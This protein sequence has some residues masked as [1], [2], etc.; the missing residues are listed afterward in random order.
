MAKRPQVRTQRIDGNQEQID[1]LEY[2]LEQI[3][4]LLFGAEGEDFRVL[5]G[6]VPRTRNLSALISRGRQA[7]LDV[8]E[9]LRFLHAELG[10]R[11]GPA[12]AGGAPEFRA[13]LA[14]FR[15]HRYQTLLDRPETL[16]DRV[17]PTLR[18]EVA[19]LMTRG[20]S[21]LAPGIAM[22]NAYAW[23]AVV[24][25]PDLEA[26]LLG[27]SG[28]A[29]TLPPPAPRAAHARDKIRKAA[30]RHIGPGL[31]AYLEVVYGDLYDEYRSQL[32]RLATTTEPLA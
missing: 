21:N 17:P 13:D 15:Y 19:N 10:R 29:V 2:F 28:A 27:P 1:Q 22:M 3:G 4:R 32:A 31:A 16:L 7:G 26:E 5:A 25:L 24:G 11:R 9:D 8:A 30:R 20:L 23:L 6:Y 12:D 14:C 18:L